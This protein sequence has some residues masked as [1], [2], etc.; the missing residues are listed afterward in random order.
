MFTTRNRNGALLALGWSALLAACDGGSSQPEVTPA[1]AP[2]NAPSRIPGLAPTMVAA[3]SAGKTASAISVHFTLGASP[4]INQALPVDIAIVPHRKF[5]SV[6]G[7]FESYDGLNMTV[8]KEFGPKSNTDVDK[9]LPHQL[10]LL[11]VKEGVSMISVVLETEGDEGSVT[12]VFS[13]PVI[14]QP[15]APA[16]EP[17]EP[18]APA[19][20][21]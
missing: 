12:R 10:V 1:R 4:S 9:V 2:V 3:V 15:S 16:A 14:V 17:T 19:A 8:G 20:A 11:P 7:H 6:R 5:A 13:I 18:A 21:S